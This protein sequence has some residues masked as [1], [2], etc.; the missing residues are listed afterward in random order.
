MLKKSSS[1]EGLLETENQVVGSE[2]T[3]RIAGDMELGPLDEKVATFVAT[4]SPSN[5]LVG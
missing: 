5:V 4:G 1:F 2:F 3:L